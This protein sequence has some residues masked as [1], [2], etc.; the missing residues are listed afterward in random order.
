MTTEISSNGVPDSPRLSARERRELLLNVV[1]D[2]GYCTTGELAQR[3]GVSEMT[4]RRDVA[5]LVDR[6]M[7][8][9]FHG[10]VSAL[11]SAEFRGSDYRARERLEQSVKHAIA[12]RAREMIR[13][14]DVI[15]LDAGS[16]VAELAALMAAQPVRA[17]AVTASL[18]VINALAQ[19]P[20]IEV[21]SLGGNLHNE[22][23]S[24]AGPATLAAIDE[25]RLGTLFLGASAFSTRGAFCANDFDS[26]TKRKLIEVADRVV[27]LADATKVTR[28]AMAKICD[29]EAIDV[30]ITDHGLDESVEHALEEH[31][32]ELALTSPLVTN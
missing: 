31:Q 29:W 21:M 2:Q 13:E 11:T 27:L 8:R 4:I 10:G 23:L 5:G 16:T 6:G 17:H 12:L 25:L 9:S 20:H 3:F 26:L 28:T 32:V 24:F 30:L 22:A 15:G 18:P 19:A 1:E 7:L 14:G